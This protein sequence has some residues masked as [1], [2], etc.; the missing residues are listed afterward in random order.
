M[1]YMARL[2]IG[3]AQRS[4]VARIEVVRLEGGGSEE[5][6]ERRNLS[7]AVPLVDAEEHGRG[8]S[9]AGDDRGVAAGGVF[10]QGCEAGLSVAQLYLFHGCLR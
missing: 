10:D 3:V 6:T 1:K 5:G 9:I 7:D 8:L 2:Q 4:G